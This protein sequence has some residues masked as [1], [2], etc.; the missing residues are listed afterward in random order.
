M[1]KHDLKSGMFVILRCGDKCVVQEEHKIFV[2]IKDGTYLRFDIINDDL[3]HID[4]LSNLDIM[5]VYKDYTC[6]KLLWQRKEKF[7]LTEDEKTIL[8]NIPEKWKLIARDKDG[9][10]RIYDNKPI[11]G[12]YSWIVHNLY[13]N[14]DLFGHLFE[15]IKWED[16]EP[17]CIKDL[18]EERD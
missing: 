18:L 2:D 13:E 16:E 1:K 4:N 3:N 10:L 14:L 9:F 8:R 6:Q 5:K 15:F 12:R 7:K 17:Y 11:R